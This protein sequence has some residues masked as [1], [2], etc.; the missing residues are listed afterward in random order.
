MRSDSILSSRL[1]MV[2]CNSGASCRGP[3]YT[4]IAGL[5]DSWKGWVRCGPAASDE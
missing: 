5:Q 1:D 2:R 4:L 3:M